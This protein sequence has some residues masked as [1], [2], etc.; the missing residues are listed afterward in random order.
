MARHS[1]EPF[2]EGL[3]VTVLATGRDLC[4]AARR[5]PRRVCPLD[6]G[7]LCHALTK[8]RVR[9]ALAL[10]DIGDADSILYDATPANKATR[11]NDDLPKLVWPLYTGL[12]RAQL[13]LPLPA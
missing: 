8:S 7:A 1:A 6:S 12:G 3:R 13:V 9:F 10:E 4:A 5:I 2:G 11:S